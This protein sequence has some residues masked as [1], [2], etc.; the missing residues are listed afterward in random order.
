MAAA[1]A[2]AACGPE[3]KSQASAPAGVMTGLD[4]LEETGF[5]ELQGK[6]IGLITNHTG[7]DRRGRGIVEVLAKAPGVTLV[8]LFSPEHGFTG[9]SEDLVVSSSSLRLGEREIPVH[10]LYSGGIAGMRPSQEDLEG[11]DALV[12]DI[13]DIGARFYT[14]L[15]TMGMALEEA[16]KAGVEFIV[17]DRPNP[18]NG[19]TMEG[20][21][22]DDPA[23]RLVTPTAYFPVPVRHGMTAGEIALLHNAEVQHPR[24]TVVKMRGWKRDMWFDQTGLPW[25]APSPNM[26]DLE[27]ATVYP[28]IAVFE[29]SNLA[30]GRGTPVPFRWVG[31]PWLDAEAV[32][33]AMNSFPLD[34]VQFSVQDYTPAKSVFEGRLCRGVRI[35]VTDRQALRPLAVFRRL[36]ETLMR[37]HPLEFEWRWDEAKRMVGTDEFR[38]LIEGGEDPEMIKALFESGPER[39]RKVR[40]PFL[41]Y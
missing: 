19:A 28:G 15:A 3:I 22:L 16:K 13:Q 12:F 27:A 14:Y 5:K 7:K 9:A 10:S 40:E 23:L 24:L 26:P 38:R 39:F 8:S 4:V 2:L 37:L 35:T 33:K 6:R 30:V 32:S 41:L 21:L 31:A 1:F 20:P 11:L 25:T 34:G 29:A 18:I 17:L 36:N